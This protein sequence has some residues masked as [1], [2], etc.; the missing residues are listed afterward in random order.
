MKYKVEITETLQRIV[1]VEAEHEIDAIREV[2]SLYR[3]GDE[4]LDANDF[5]GVK[6]RCIG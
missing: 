5:V 6:M 1:E 4:V 3:S 2:R